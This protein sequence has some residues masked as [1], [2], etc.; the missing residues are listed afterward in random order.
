MEFHDRLKEL[1]EET[2]KSQKEFATEI[3]IETT[4]YNKWENG[5][6]APGYMDLVFLARK[7]NVSTDYLLGKSPY[8]N[9]DVFKASN[10]QVEDILRSLYGL[11]PEVREYTLS[12]IENLLRKSGSGFTHSAAIVLKKLATVMDCFANE[13]ELYIKFI[14]DTVFEVRQLDEQGK[15]EE[16]EERIKRNPQIYKAALA[17]TCQHARF[18]I[19]ELYQS[20]GPLFECNLVQA[21]EISRANTNYGKEPRIIDKKTIND[22]NSGAKDGDMNA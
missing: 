7:L 10:G 11:S 6:N 20:L 4:K 8:P 19:D 18:E 14:S 16:A 12:S 21:V 9:Y 15:S 5:K 22:K 17:D 13:R 2:G 1:R 3:G